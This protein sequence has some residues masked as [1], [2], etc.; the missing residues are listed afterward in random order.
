MQRLI[1]TKL[2]RVFTRN[3]SCLLNRVVTFIV[4]FT[5]VHSS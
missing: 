1:V 3:E 5:Y 4:L 2:S